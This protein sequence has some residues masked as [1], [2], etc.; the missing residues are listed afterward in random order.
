MQEH[1]AAAAG[2]ARRAVVI[3]LDDKIIE[4][5]VAGEPIAAAIRLEPHRLVVVPVLGVFAPGVFGPDRARRQECARPRVAVG[6]PPQLARPERPSGG[7]AV[8]FPLVGLDASAPQRDRNGL[9]ADGQ[10]ATARIAGGGANK[11]RR[12]RATVPG[13]RISN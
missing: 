8:T 4:G 9:P 10:P 13:F 3:D 5:V 6:A 7:A 1:R 2:D 12:N 11:D